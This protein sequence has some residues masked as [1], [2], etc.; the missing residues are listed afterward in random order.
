MQAKAKKTEGSYILNGKKLSLSRA[1]KNYFAV[2]FTK[3]EEGVSCFLVDQETEG[4]NVSGNTERTGWLSRVREPLVLSF[5]NCKVAAE[6]LLGEAGKAF[7]LGLKWLPQRRI[8]RSARSVGMAR[9]LLEEAALQAQSASAFGQPAQKRTSVRAALAEMAA[10]IH[11]SRLMVYEAACMADAGK[12]IHHQATMVKLHT[13]R[14]LQGVADMASHV[15]NGPSC[16]GQPLEK[17]CRHA[18]E[19]RVQ[20]F[21]LE[22]QRNIIAADILKGLKA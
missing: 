15:F 20:E 2:V 3:A 1:D 17:L 14:M 6:N 18:I 19:N 13:A 9:R 16:A 22:K 21:A 5:E 8:V 4:F 12:T 7:K 11:A 10:G